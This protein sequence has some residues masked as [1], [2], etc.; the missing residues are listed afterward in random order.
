MKMNLHWEFSLIKTVDHN[1]LLSKLYCYG[2]EGA[3]HQLFKSYLT[4]SQQHTTINHQ[5]SNLSSIKYSAPQC[6]V[7]GLQLFLLYINDLN[8]AFVHSKVHHFASDTNFL[9]TIH[10]LKSFITVI[11]FSLSYLV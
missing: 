3:P 2:V 7:L 10:S 5:K 8:K 9:Y 4:G 6:S 11:N 1:I